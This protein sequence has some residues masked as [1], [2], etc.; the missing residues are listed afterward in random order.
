[1]ILPQKYVQ[2]Q[3]SSTTGGYAE[4][5]SEIQKSLHALSTS[6]Y[7]GSLGAIC[8]NVADAADTSIGDGG[9]VSGVVAINAG[10]NSYKNGWA[11]A[12]ELESFAQRNDTILSGM[13]TLGLNKSG[14]CYAKSIASLVCAC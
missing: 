11:I 8:Y 12:Q 2:L 6:F 7:A 13:N 4:A 14:P 10:A 3:N 9:T 1:M 5:F